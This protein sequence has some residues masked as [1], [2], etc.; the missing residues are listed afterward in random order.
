[1]ATS[2]L[3]RA[4][5]GDMSADNFGLFWT[6]DFYVGDEWVLSAGLRYTDESKSVSIITG[7]CDDNTDFDCS[8]DDLKGD[9]SNV[10]PRIGVQWNFGRVG[11][12]PGQALEQVDDICV[13]GFRV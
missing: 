6:N 4:L 2:L 9:W 13:A 12:V 10:T 3:Q 1:M 8:Y 11:A 5:G 7:V